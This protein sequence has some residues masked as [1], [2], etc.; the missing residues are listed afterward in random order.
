M[1]AQAMYYNFY[2][3][4]FLSAEVNILLHKCVY[5]INFIPDNLATDNNK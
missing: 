3:S 1:L 5:L 4:F 2:Q